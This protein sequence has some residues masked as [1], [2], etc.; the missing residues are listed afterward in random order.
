[1]KRKRL[2]VLAMIPQIEQ[3][4][5]HFASSSAS[6]DV[7][8]VVLGDPPDVDDILAKYR[9][10]RP[11]VIGIIGKHTRSYLDILD[12]LAV[13]CPSLALTPR[14]YRCQNTN[15]SG[16]VADDVPLE[17][18]IA[19]SHWVKEAS[20]PRFGLVLAQT[21]TDVGILAR[22]LA[23]ALVYPCPYGF[24]PGLFN[25]EFPE[26]ERP[27]DIGCY[28]TVA[29]A[30]HGWKTVRRDR[31]QELLRAVCHIAE[32]RGW[33]LQVTEGRYW[34]DYVAL[35]RRTKVCLHRSFC[36]DIPFRLHET[37]ALG[38]VFATDP[39]RFGIERLYAAG[40]EYL[41]YRDDLSNLEA[42]LASV[43]DH[44]DTWRRIS[45]AG[46]RRARHYSWP[47]IADDYV[48]PAVCE[49]LRL[50]EQAL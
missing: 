35:I 1:M 25:P 15:L 5:G 7:A 38:S 6:M 46:R 2:R 28:F 10:A 40:S 3:R 24:D 33:N 16:S 20:D 29:G 26:I 27:V 19:R 43:L 18:I 45:E 30:S 31:R 41:E 4:I 42:M 22:V 14:V 39:L 9:E 17:E 21:L 32:R 36:G 49:V 37:T 48:Y 13:G 34:D 23:P 44:P 11:H 8:R 12:S 47:R 50:R